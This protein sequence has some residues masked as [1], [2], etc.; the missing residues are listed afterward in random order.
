M[1]RADDGDASDGSEGSSMVAT[2]STAWQ[3]G[4]SGQSEASKKRVQESLATDFIR[5]PT[6]QEFGKGRFAGKQILMSIFNSQHF[7][8]FM[9]LVIIVDAYCICNDIDSRAAQT[10]SPSGLLL[11]SY[12][13][14]SLYT[15]ELALNL[16][17]NG[18]QVLRQNLIRLDLF[19]V[20]CG[21]TELLSDLLMP[22]SA[23]TSLSLLRIL[24]LVRVFRLLKLLRNVRALRELS[25][26]V[27]M[28]ST[29]MKALFWSF[30]FCF[31][32]MTVWAMLIVEVVHPLV[33][34][35]EGMNEECARW[36]SSVM[37]ANLLLFRTVIAG[38]SWG[39]IAVPVIEAHPSTA[40]IFVGAYL[41]IV[42][43]VLNLIVAV[44]VDQFADA[45]ERDV[46]NLADE[47]ER[48]QQIDQKYLQKIFDQIDK[49]G[50]G[51]LSFNELLQ[52]ARKNPEFQSRLR[53]MDIDE[54]DLRELFQMIDVDGSG[55]IE[56]H[57]FIKPL[58]RWVHD[59]KTAP[60]FIKYNMIRCVHQQQELANAV[61]G[62]F[63]EL[64]TRMEKLSAEVQEVL[65]HTA[66]TIETSEPKEILERRLELPELPEP[67]ELRRSLPVTLK[68][69]KVLCEESD[70]REAV[71]L[72]TQQ[73]R[74]AL[75]AVGDLEKSTEAT[76]EQLQ[77]KVPSS[78]HPSQ[79]VSLSLS[80]RK[81]IL[82]SCEE[83]LEDRSFGSSLRFST[84]STALPD[85][86]VRPPDPTGVVA[87]AAL[88]NEL[89][90]APGPHD[91]EI[92]HIATLAQCDRNT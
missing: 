53:V 51:E 69:A 75:R 5:A 86:L 3:R 37:E 24:R 30:C 79:Q 19:L 12:L 78:S 32:V 6:L 67:S 60:R 77:A 55:S 65:Q 66:V 40:L 83:D 87:P 23:I 7:S 10:K 2:A 90:R 36:T 16:L 71:Q 42:F 72:A 25:K 58:S 35:L 8:H 13:C 15:I 74:E 45:R 27:K 70:F 82:P 81:P 14:L 88:R 62:V 34:D 80:A 39:E 33:K 89:Q 64:S 76:M 54:G 38:D 61:E 26:L 29:C 41:T 1:A 49:E 57:E 21:Y 4:T 31:M 68:E 48:D 43:G 11:V 28:M 22:S 91:A 9:A 85:P 50:K 18:R 63:V 46:L 84:C 52:G 56:S 73:L 17:L 20:L 47:M 92:E 59:S 44:V